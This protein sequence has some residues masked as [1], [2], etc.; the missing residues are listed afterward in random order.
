MNIT[1]GDYKIKYDSGI[2]CTITKNG[3]SK[4][5]NVGITTVFPRAIASEIA[6]ASYEKALYKMRVAYTIGQWPTDPCPHC[7]K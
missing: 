2:G 1:V 3:E 5:T 7:G 4:V 6:S